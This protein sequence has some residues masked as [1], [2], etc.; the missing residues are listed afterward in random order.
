MDSNIAEILPNWRLI[1]IF[2]LVTVVMGG[3]A[4]WL[5][6]RALAATWR[7]WWHVAGYMLILSAGVRFIHFALFQSRL[8]APYLYIVDFAVCLMF[9]L[10]GFR[11]MRVRQMV[12]RYNWINEREG[13]FGWRR[14][15]AG[16]RPESG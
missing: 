9:G 14:R 13:L 3:G 12:T 8:L 7:P 10:I 4:G 2:L 1:G 5:A 15:D 6:G 11:L 16:E